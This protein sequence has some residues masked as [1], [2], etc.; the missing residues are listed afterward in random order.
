MRTRGG[1]SVIKNFKNIKKVENII[2]FCDVPLTLY[3]VGGGAESARI[4]LDCLGLS[5]G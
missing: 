1:L 4:V 2:I 5:A 3:G